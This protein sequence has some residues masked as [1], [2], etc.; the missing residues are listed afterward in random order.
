MLA[1]PEDHAGALDA[2]YSRMCNEL[3][4]LVRSAQAE[5][6][7][8]L[9][10][11]ETSWEY[12][13]A[14]FASRVAFESLVHDYEAYS[15]QT[16]YRAEPSRC[17]SHM[18]CR[19][20]PL[21]MVPLRVD[22]QVQTLTGYSPDAVQRDVWQILHPAGR[23]EARLAFDALGAA[24][25]DGQVDH[26]AFLLKVLHRDGFTVWARV[27]A[28]YLTRVEAHPHVVVL[29]LRNDSEKHWVTLFLEALGRTREQLSLH[30]HSR[31]VLRE[32]DRYLRRFEA[33]ETER[34][35][36]KKSIPGFLAQTSSLL[37]SHV[38]NQFFPR[39]R[40]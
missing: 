22:E 25:L 11:R 33:D 36:F 15:A 10:R 16:V 32:I 8:A 3:V 40:R 29:T 31:G 7:E 23:E 18:V 17:A 6:E 9:K 20:E 5:L 37:A 28:T 19:L 27:S 38:A 1:F 4:G 2:H 13:A 24:M 26:T 14:F 34:A 12:A 21:G 35:G 39:L 30:G